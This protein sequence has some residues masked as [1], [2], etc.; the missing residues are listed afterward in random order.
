MD[1]DCQNLGEIL[2][3]VSFLVRLTGKRNLYRERERDRK[4][5]G[6][7]SWKYLVGMVS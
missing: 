3:P 2:I 5:I 7:P 1:M 4:G 6:D